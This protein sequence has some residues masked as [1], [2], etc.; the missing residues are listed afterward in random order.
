MATNMRIMEYE[1]ILLGRRKNF[2]AACMGSGT[3]EKEAVEVLRYAFEKILRWDPDMILAYANAKIIQ[4][5]HLQRV[6][7]RVH[8]PAE[9]DE[10][11]DLFYLAQVLYPERIRYS[12]QKTVLHI[13]QQVVSRQLTK[14]PKNF[15][16]GNEGLVNAGICLQYAVNQDMQVRSIKELYERFSDEAWARRFLRNERLYVPFYQNYEYPIDMLHDS[17][18]EESRS[19]FFYRHYRFK[20]EYNK[21]KDEI[22]EE[23]T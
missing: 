1:E 7:T 22:K 11:R 8:F 23:T 2:S 21:I 19:E 18:P 16:L 13:Y 12:K 14:Y 3:R 17:L 4:Y 15:F 9:L 6:I 20:A 10:T 5:L